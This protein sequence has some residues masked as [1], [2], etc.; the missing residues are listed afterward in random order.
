M[1][2]QNYCIVK[3][4][5]YIFTCFFYW[6]LLSLTNQKSFTMKKHIIT[7]LAITACVHVRGQSLAPELI[8]SS[9]GHGQSAQ[10][11]LSWS[12]GEP[13]ISTLSNSNNTLTQGFHQ[14]QIV[15]TSLESTADWMELKIF[16]NPATD[17][18]I[19]QIDEVGVSSITRFELFDL[20]GKSIT[21]GNVTTTRTEIPAGNLAAGQYVLRVSNSQKVKSFQIIKQK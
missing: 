5:S 2:S 9:G 13:V 16:P 7:L 20:Q 10:T 12:V 3:G 11:Q 15:V 21:K 18:V 17:L 1:L 6:Q 19:L 8:S 14:P 4:T